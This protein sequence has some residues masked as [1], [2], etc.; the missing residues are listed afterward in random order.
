M[1]VKMGG[2]NSSSSYRC[3]LCQLRAYHQKLLVAVSD[4]SSTHSSEHTPLD[5]NAS[6]LMTSAASVVNDVMVVEDSDQ[7]SD[8]PA[9]IPRQSTVPTL[10][11]SPSTINICDDPQIQ[12][13]LREEEAELEAAM[14]VTPRLAQSSPPPLFT[15]KD[16]P[17]SKLSDYLEDFIAHR[18]LSCGYDRSVAD[19][20]TIRLVSNIEA[21]VEVPDIVSMNLSADQEGH[22]L[23]SSLPYRQK[24]ILLFQSIDGYDTLLFCLYVQEFDGHCPAPNTGAAYIAYLDSVDYFQPASA[25]TMVYHELLVGYLRFIQHRGFQRVQIWSC[26]PRKGDNFIFWRHPAYQKTPQRDRLNRWYEE[27]ISRCR[28]L[29]MM[30][31]G[32]SSKSTGAA[33]LF[34]LYFSNY[35]HKDLSRDGDDSCGSGIRQAARQS[36]CGSRLSASHSTIAPLIVCCPPLFE[37]D[38]WLDQYRKAYHHIAQR[39]ALSYHHPEDLAGNLRRAREVIKDLSACPPYSSYFLQPVDPVALKIESYRTI[40]T[41]PMDLGTIRQKLESQSYR[42]YYELGRDIQLTM[43][44]AMIF[45][46]SP[47]HPVH[48]AAQQLYTRY[49]QQTRV[50]LGKYYPQQGGDSLVVP[51]GDMLADRSLDHWEAMLRG[52][53]LIA[54]PTKDAVSSSLYRAVSIE[55]NL[56]LEERQVDA[57]DDMRRPA[58]EMVAVSHRL[59]RNSSIVSIAPSEESAPPQKLEKPAIGHRPLLQVMFEVAKSVAKDKDSLFV[60]QFPS[61]PSPVPPPPPLAEPVDSQ[62]V[63]QPIKRGR[64]RIPRPVY[65]VPAVAPTA[66]SGMPI[67]S[68]TGEM[69][70][71]TLRPDTSDPDPLTAPSFLSYRHSFLDLCQCYHFQFDSLRR[72]KHSSRM[73]LQHYAGALRGT[74]A[75]SCASCGQRCQH[76]RYHCDVC[77]GPSRTRYEA[78]QRCYH[79]MT[80]LAPS[81]AEYLPPHP[82]PLT[83]YRLFF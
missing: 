28:E 66:A 31:G 25:R 53:I 33:N 12:A 41:H 74:M 69:M 21:S 78:C 52:I 30:E 57:D 81:D 9:V 27:M 38:Y 45:N 54:V 32:G 10:A 20:L 76:I 56:Y 29:G 67:F 43:R 34:D 6:G 71:S 62:G 17:R 70:L 61:A 59:Y 63:S 8:M 77:Q 55:E 18:L 82:H 64:G 65:K 68:S 3:P 44:N 36:W 60:I 1:H 46:A 19:S 15:A 13:A 79:R 51:G 7:E 75:L 4:T 26:P 5:C 40:I 49:L 16:I 37:G 35:L 11:C 22:R 50:L 80:Q 24:C 48:I 2:E 73:I 72:A 47:L 14:E 83:P 42:S 23:S 58:D 39:V